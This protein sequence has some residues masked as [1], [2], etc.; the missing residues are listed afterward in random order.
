MADS[1]MIETAN[2]TRTGIAI[3]GIIALFIGAI[4]A[5]LTTRSITAPMKKR[6]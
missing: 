2:S 4:L 3:I 1:E 6:S 5:F